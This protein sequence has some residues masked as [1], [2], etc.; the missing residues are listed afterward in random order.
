MTMN[1]MELSRAY[2]DA[3]GRDLIEN[4]YGVCQGQLAAGLVGEGSFR[5][6]VLYLDAEAHV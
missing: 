2:F 1:G 6:R 3:Y 4:K 5:A